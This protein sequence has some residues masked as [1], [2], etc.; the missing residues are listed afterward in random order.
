MPSTVSQPP[1]RLLARAS[2]YRCATCPPERVC[3]W[4]CIQ[5]AGME[6]IVAGAALAERLGPLPTGPQV[7]DITSVRLCLWE[8]YNI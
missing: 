5:G 2:A 8:R 7:E 6:D 1:V 3:A 4:A